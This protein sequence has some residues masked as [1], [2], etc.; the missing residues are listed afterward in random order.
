MVDVRT[1][2]ITSEQREGVGTVIK[3]TSE[4]FGLPV[5]HDVME[6]TA[7]EPGKEM[8]VV[9]RGQFTGS[10]SFL[11]SP[12]SGGTVFRWLE[13]FDPPLGPAGE[14]AH[15]LF[16]KPHLRRVFKRSMNNV[17][18]LAEAKASA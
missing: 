18:A 5:I 11:L 1:L 12:T 16:V 10:A 6:I 2:E 15:L 17:K 13:T 7:W 3:V 9:H 4:L 14:V 8:S